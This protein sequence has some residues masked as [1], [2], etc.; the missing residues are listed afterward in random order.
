V[1]NSIYGEL[2]HMF[3]KFLKYHMNILSDFNAK[4]GRE[5]FILTIENEGLHE[6]SNYYG[7][8]VVNFAT[9]KNF[10]IKTAMFPHHHIHKYT[11]MSPEG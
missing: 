4:V 9:S 3:N 6:I 2:E 8:G 11:W 5:D 1:R 7:I 10:I